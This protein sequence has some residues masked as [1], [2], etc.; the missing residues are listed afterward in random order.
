M[1]CYSVGLMTKWVR[2][3]R[4][5]AFLVIGLLVVA[6]SLLYSNG[7]DP[8]RG[9]LRSLPRMETEL[10]QSRVEFSKAL[11]GEKGT[12]IAYPTRLGLL[13]GLVIAGIGVIVFFAERRSE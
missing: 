13:V 8:K 6:T 11:M 1:T 10:Y 9:F 12:R 4:A 7:Y 2:R 5:V 3:R